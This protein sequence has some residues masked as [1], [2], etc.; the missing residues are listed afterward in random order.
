MQTSPV[1]MEALAE[2]SHATPEDVCEVLADAAKANP[3]F[4]DNELIALYRGEFTDVGS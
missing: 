1:L 3:T 4:N 2:R